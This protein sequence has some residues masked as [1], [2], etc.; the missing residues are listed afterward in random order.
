[1]LEEVGA[2]NFFLFGNTVE[3]IGQLQN[4]GYRPYDFYE[5]SE[6]L[7]EVI[8][9]IESGFLSPGDTDL[10]HPLVGNLLHSDPFFVLADF[11]AYADCQD[12]V[13]KVY[14]ERAR[15]TRM[16]VLNVARSGKFSS[17]RAIQEYCRDIWHVDPLKV[18]L[19]RQHRLITLPSESQ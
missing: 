10:F 4:R 16:S 15:W 13:G 7:R 18:S 9:L 17:D 12:R 14:Q 5:S 6:M 19:I 3:E 8:D 2:E 11:Q 1:M